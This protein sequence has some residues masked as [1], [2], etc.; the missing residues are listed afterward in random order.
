MDRL[1]E[2]A[3]Q[4]GTIAVNREFVNYAK[5]AATYISKLEKK[6]RM[7]EQLQEIN[8]DSVST[9]KLA[10]EIEDLVAA[11]E[12]PP[13]PSL[14][15]PPAVATA[16]SQASAPAIA[17]GPVWTPEEI[18]EWEAWQAE[19]W[20]GDDEGHWDEE[21]SHAGC[22]SPWSQ[23]AQRQSDELRR[24]SRS[25]SLPS[26]SS[27]QDAPRKPHPFPPVPEAPELKV[28]STTHRAEYMRL[29]SCL[30]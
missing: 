11:P 25:A 15:T 13:S 29:A 21:E 8:E 28:N 3:S 5:N 9:D 26:S 30:L 6:I 4:S 2:S 17:N 23:D 19:K 16:Q 14:A 27:G 1:G 24:A 18:E 20:V 22:E 10:R 12:R 7:L